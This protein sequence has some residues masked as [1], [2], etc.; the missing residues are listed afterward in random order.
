MMNKKTTELLREL[1][2]HLS[3]LEI[4]T[5]AG[6]LPMAAASCGRRILADVLESLDMAANADL[7]AILDSDEAWAA[8]AVTVEA[9]TRRIESAKN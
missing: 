9:V 5:N 1:E 3:A 2:S 6:V 7:P 8:A 4:T